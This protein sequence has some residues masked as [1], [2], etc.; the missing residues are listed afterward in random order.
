[1]IE[2]GE[3]ETVAETGKNQTNHD[4]TKIKK[5]KG[6]VELLACLGTN[7]KKKR[8]SFTTLQKELHKFILVNYHHTSDIT[9]VVKE[10]K[11]P[12][13]RLTKDMPTLDKLKE[14][15]VIYPSQTT[16]SADEIDI[17]DNLKELLG[18]E[19]KTLYYM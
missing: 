8:D 17:I 16:S 2:A 4:T 1:M 7:K 15:W 18:P 5:F 11:N 14:D 19:R 10:L 13:P 12:L 6:T 9:Y 3:G